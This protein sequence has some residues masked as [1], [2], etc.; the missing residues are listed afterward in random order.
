MKNLKSC[1]VRALQKEKTRRTLIDAAFNQLNAEQGFA[2]LSLREVSRE[3]GIAATSFYRHFRDMDELGL[4]MVDES[5]LTL[6]QLMRQAR[7]RIEKGGSVL[8]TSVTTFIEFIDRNPKVFLLLL[9][10]KAGTS[11][12]FRSAVAREI[13]HFIVELVDYL[14]NANNMPHHYN[15]A[16][17]Q[18]M[19]T[20]AFNVGA[21]AIDLDTEK[22]EKLIENLIFQLRM[23]SRGAYYLYHKDRIKNEII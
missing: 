6:R 17:A 23:V 2:S 7:K 11:S 8:Q 18:A 22:R 1:G 4:A 21:E 5:G 20:I 3:A 16:Q 12:A 13:Q 9:R 19:V 15:E 14:D 10:E